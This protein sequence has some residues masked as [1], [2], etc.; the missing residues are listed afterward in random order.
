MQAGRKP[1]E[2]RK[3]AMLASLNCQFA[4]DLWKRFCA[5]LGDDG[6][7]LAYHVNR[8]PASRQ[9]LAKRRC[10]LGCSQWQSACRK[11]CVAVL[12]Q[13]PPDHFVLFPDV[14]RSFGQKDRL[15]SDPSMSDLCI[16]RDRY[17]RTFDHL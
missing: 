14:D 17:I 12:L 4:L 7:V 10:H 8:H 5:P 11:H 6:V 2:A 1:Y 15:L 16:R 13:I 3:A 9:I